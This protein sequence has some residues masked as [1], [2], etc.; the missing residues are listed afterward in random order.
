[1][2]RAGERPTLSMESNMA[3][4]SCLM[5]CLTALASMLMQAKIA[6]SKLVSLFLLAPEDLALVAPED[7]RV[8]ARPPWLSGGRP[9]RIEVRTFLK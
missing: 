9:C 5:L 7:P 8:P 1:M 2:V 6:G 3:L 4:T